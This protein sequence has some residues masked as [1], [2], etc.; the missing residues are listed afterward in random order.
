MQIFLNTVFFVQSC[1]YK[2]LPISL[3]IFFGFQLTSVSRRLLILH[4]SAVFTFA[5]SSDVI[6]SP[7]SVAYWLSNFN[8]NV[9]VVIV[10]VFLC[11]KLLECVLWCCIRLLLKYRF[12]TF[13]CRAIA[14]FSRIL[15]IVSALRC[16]RTNSYRI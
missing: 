3:S 16:F 15:F 7:Q 5:W 9:L 8:I 6:V 13:Y 10:C 2:L 12:K 4:F 14:F 1:G 11:F